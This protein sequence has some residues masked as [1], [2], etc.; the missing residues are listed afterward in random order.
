M[1]W[2]KVY[3]L[4]LRHFYLIKSSF[5]RI[6]D[7]IY[8]PSIQ[9]FLWG[10]ISKFFT[11]SSS[12]Y[13]N[14]VGVILSA[15]ILYDFLFRSSISYNMMFL[16]EIWS[17]NFTNLFISPIKI[18][19]IIAAL[20]L[21]AIFRTLIGTVP[22][23]LLAIPLFG[24]SVFKIGFPLIVL[25]LSLYIFGVTLG[26]LVTSGL[27]RFGPSFENIAWASLF[28]LAPLGCIYY[29]IDILPEWLQII[30][31]LLPLVHI[32]EE[33]RNI[34]INNIISY[35]QIILAIIISFLYFI[36]AIK[37]FYISYNGAKDRG[38]LINIG[39]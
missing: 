3:G 8:W 39:E 5:P 23:A 27:I 1:N 19:E 15:A 34:L 13:N 17:R 33:M 20:T 26:L 9:I 25:L 28:F 32:F 12:Y 10:F 11:L 22:A 36:M 31:I 6:L 18:K 24:V 35:N 29:P 21:T 7:L 14:T 37:V 30:A 38:T 4:S 16:E 2:H